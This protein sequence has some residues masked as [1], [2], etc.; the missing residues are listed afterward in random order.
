MYAGFFKIMH[1][2]SSRRFAAFLAAGLML[3]LV[4][5]RAEALPP[6]HN[7]PSPQHNPGK[8]VWADLFTADPAA[9][10]DFYTK[11]LGWTSTTLF[12]KGKTYTVF[13]NNGHPVAGLVQRSAAKT[14]RPSRWIGYIAVNDAAATLATVTKA[15]G[16]VHA[17][18][19]NFPDRGTQAIIGDTEGSPI[20]LLQ[21]SSGDSADDEPQPGDWNWFELYAQKPTDACQFYSQVFGFVAAP[22]TRTERKDDFMLSS[23]DVPRAG[24][25]PLPDR[26]D[27]KPGWLG[28]IRVANLDATLAK[29]AG[30]GGEV[31]LAPR[32][33][34]YESRFAIIADP[35]GGA[36]GLVEYVDNANP[37]TAPVPAT[38][39]SP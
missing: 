18:A 2:T 10:T 32:V 20:G 15:G 36:V 35:T 29:V 4:S 33:A 34:A 6:L 17:P 14:K 8:F 28:V 12:Q 23:G 7:P 19:R 37:A 5:A 11:L 27:A 30:L 1:T 9:A 31:L 13:S 3:G 25:A 24:I 38:P 16:E 21:S 22:D 39:S 26:D